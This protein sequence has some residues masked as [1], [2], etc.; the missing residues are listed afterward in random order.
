MSSKLP[1]NICL[2]S[3][4][5]LNILV[6]M[7]FTLVILPSSSK[8]GSTPLSVFFLNN[9]LNCFQNSNASAALS[10]HRLSSFPHQTAFWFLP[11]WLFLDLYCALGRLSVP[12]AFCCIVLSIRESNMVYYD[13]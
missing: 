12:C 11:L 1:T 8:R 7:S 3:K 10:H 13:L 9:L 6:S 4:K 2:L 5:A